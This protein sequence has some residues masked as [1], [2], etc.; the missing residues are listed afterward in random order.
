MVRDL[1]ERE[2][3]KEKQSKPKNDEEL[4]DVV[5]RPIVT[6]TP[7]QENMTLSV[8]D[9]DQDGCGR[10]MFSIYDDTTEA[11]VQQGQSFYDFLYSKEEPSQAGALSGSHIKDLGDENIYDEVPLEGSTQSLSSVGKR[12]SNN[13]F[14][15]YDEVIINK[16]T[17]II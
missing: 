2:G 15:I 16:G 11:T 3:Q 1:S 9:L 10:R 6:S 8:E 13:G 7:F 5:S 14:D 4:R 12:R 17:F